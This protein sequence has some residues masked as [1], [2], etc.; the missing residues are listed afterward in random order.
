MLGLKGDILTFA[1]IL[2]GCAFGAWLPTF[3]DAAMPKRRR[4]ILWIL[5]IALIVMGLLS[6]VSAEKIPLIGA[7][8]AEVG[9]NPSI[10]IFLVLFI[11]AITVWAPRAKLKPQE[12]T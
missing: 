2:W 12:P 8:A 9:S 1:G 5:A 10:W 11:I 4:I 6:G 7:K 3:L